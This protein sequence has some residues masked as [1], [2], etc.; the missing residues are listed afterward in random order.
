MC[1]SGKGYLTDMHCV[2]V[3]TELTASELCEWLYSAGSFNTLVSRSFTSTPTQE[4]LSHTKDV[5]STAGQ[6]P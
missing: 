3:E 2:Y 1:T 4:I 5:R 6:G